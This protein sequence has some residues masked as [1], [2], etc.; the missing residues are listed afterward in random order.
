MATVNNNAA[1]QVNIHLELCVLQV[2]TWLSVHSDALGS[3]SSAICP[4]CSHWFYDAE[5]PHS[6]QLPSSLDR[7]CGR[8]SRARQTDKQL[9]RQRDTA[10]HCHSNLFTTVRESWHKSVNYALQHH[11]LPLPISLSTGDAEGANLP[12]MCWYWL[13]SVH[14][15]IINS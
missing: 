14:S 8:L 11:C 7:A 12:Q 9:I 3:S 10:E 5:R 4:S 1:W 13:L 15:A 2:Q 6:R